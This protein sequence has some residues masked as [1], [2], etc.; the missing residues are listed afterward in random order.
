MNIEDAMNQIQ[1]DEDANAKHYAELDAANAQSERYAAAYEEIERLTVENEVTK[2]EASYL[3]CHYLTARNAELETR[4]EAA[5]ILLKSLYHSAI[6]TLHH[7]D[8]SRSDAGDDWLLRKYEKNGRY[9]AKRFANA[10]DA[11]LSLEQND[12]Q[13]CEI[14]S[15]GDFVP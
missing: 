13:D 2:K 12:D 6:F 9:T 14:E 11:Y 5:E 4:L 10:I 8:I 15:D 7:A 3:K 1:A